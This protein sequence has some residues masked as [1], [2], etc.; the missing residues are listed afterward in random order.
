MARWGLMVFLGVAL[1]GVAVTAEAREFRIL[2]AEPVQAAQPLPRA[3]THGAIPATLRSMS[4]LAYGRQFELA[5]EPND[6]LIASLPA[7]QREALRAFPIYR[8]RLSGMPGSWVRLTQVSTTLE[9]MVW[10]GHELYTLEPARRAQPFMLDAASVPAEST[11]IYRLSDTLSDLGPQFCSVLTPPEEATSLAGYQALVA[12]LRANQA[13]VAAATLS[14][15]I[16]VAVIGDFEFFSDHPGNAESTVLTRMNV[17][18]GIFSDQ[19][20]VHIVVSSVNVFSTDTDPF[21]TSV[22]SD[23]LGQ[24]ADYKN[25]TAS[26]RSAAIAHLMTGRDLDGSTVGIAF[27]ASLCNPRFGVSLSEGGSEIGS[28]SAALVAAH[29]MGHNFGAPHDA[30]P[31]TTQNQACASTP[32][33]F[34]MAA[35]LNG[36]STFSQCSLDQMRPVIS[37]AACIQAA[38]VADAAV[39]ASPASV[40]ALVN[41]PLAYSISVSSIGTATLNAATVSMTLPASLSLQSATPDVGSCSSGAGAVTCDL[42]TLP[43]GASRRIDMVVLGSQAGSFASSIVLS[44]SNDSTTQNN[45]TSVTLLVTEPSDSSPPASGGG[46]GGGGGA[47]ALEALA[48]LL[49]LSLRWRAA[50]SCA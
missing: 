33:T 19:V 3:G 22:P 27:L 2:Y 35:S 34:L 12:E 6:R 9:G 13:L 16:Q 36:S 11:V 28:T 49:A 37:G 10:D 7:A 24:L 41:Q 20:G 48:L 25:A 29:E 46:G 15:Q 45:S 38:P 40:S 31:D 18:D 4:F 30:E 14:G 23:L 21:T 44:A 1:L 42:G 17:V 39:S 50:S 47:G 5:L 26:I 8:G 32:P 43:A